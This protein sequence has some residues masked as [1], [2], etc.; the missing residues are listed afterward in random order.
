MDACQMEGLP[1]GQFQLRK[2]QTNQE[3]TLSRAPLGEKVSVLLLLPQK[4]SSWSRYRG[5]QAGGM[6]DRKGKSRSCSLP[7]MAG[8]GGS[9]NQALTLKFQ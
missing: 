7:T 4:W 1:P 8:A 5:V 6:E 2:L 9:L 3:E